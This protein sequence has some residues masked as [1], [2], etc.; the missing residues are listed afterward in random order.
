MIISTVFQAVYAVISLLKLQFVI[1]VSVL[2]LILHFTGITVKYPIANLFLSLAL[3]ASVIYAVVSIL[4]ALLGLGGK[5]KKRRGAQ[6]VKSSK[7][8]AKEDADT[9]AETAT[10]VSENTFNNAATT[11]E[12][13]V[14]PSVQVA[15][16]RI[17][18]PKYFRV[19]QNPD[20]VM[21]EYGDRYELYKISGGSLVKIRTDF[22]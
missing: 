21:A 17:E 1:L 18:E 20:L 5:K 19:K 3:I 7:R 8:A 4:K 16:E 6:L 2:W 11:A 12:T 13:P 22:K 14:Q 15:D 9:V 10:S